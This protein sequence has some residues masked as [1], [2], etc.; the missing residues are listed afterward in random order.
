MAKQEEINAGGINGLGE[1][2]VNTNSKD[3]L[4]LKSQI[5]KLSKNHSQEQ[6]IENRFISIRFQMESYLNSS[7]RDITKAG[8]FIEKFLKVIKVKKKD[9]A[10][11]I[12]WAESNFSDLLKGRRKINS[13]V[14]LKLGSIFKMS[15]AIWLHIESKNDLLRELEG[16]EAEYK[17]YDLNDL[18]KK[19]S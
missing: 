16:K 2:L 8:D 9:F 5:K 13:D 7:S 11:Y 14:A 3:F 17:K 18:M 10:H 6:E 12:N 15:P 1:G 19:A 4:E